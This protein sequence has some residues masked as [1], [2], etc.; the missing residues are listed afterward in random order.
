MDPLRNDAHGAVAN[1]QVLFEIDLFERGVLAD[2]LDRKGRGL[3]LARDG[4]MGIACSPAVVVASD[5]LEHPLAR[6]RLAK[7]L[8][9]PTQRQNLRPGARDRD[10]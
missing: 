8:R 10:A 4:G 5:S 9:C 7:L 3:A 2:K 1:G 6:L